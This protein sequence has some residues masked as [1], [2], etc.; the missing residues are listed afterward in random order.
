MNKKGFTLVEILATLVVLA[1]VATIAF[2]SI[3]GISNRT[4]EKLYEQK[5]ENL[6][7]A[8]ILYGDDNKNEIKNTSLRYGDS[9]SSYPCAIIDAKDLVPNYLDKDNENECGG[10]SGCI[11]NPQDNTYLDE[12]KIVIYIKNNKVYA[13]ASENALLNCTAQSTIK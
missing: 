7:N 2:V 1:I 11:E 6:E 3:N 4:K 10:E 5:I 8:A 13:D 9:G 12:R